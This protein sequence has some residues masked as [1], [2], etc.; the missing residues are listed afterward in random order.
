MRPDPAGREAGEVID[1]AELVLRLPGVDRADAPALVEDILRAAQ[2]RLRGSGRVGRVHLAELRIS[3]PVGLPRDELVRRVAE[4][5]A[6]VL[7]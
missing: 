7:R 4:R 3:I 6:A 1:I 2:D 5:I